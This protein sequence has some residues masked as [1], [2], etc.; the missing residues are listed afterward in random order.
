MSNLWDV[1]INYLISR[2]AYGRP[3][4]LVINEVNGIAEFLAFWTIFL[5][6]HRVNKT[7]P[8]IVDVFCQC[9]STKHSQS[10]GLMASQQTSIAVAKAPAMSSTATIDAT[11]SAVAYLR[12][13][14]SGVAS[15]LSL[16]HSL[17]RLI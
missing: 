1:P 2:C 8:L 5:V 14:S 17:S 12:G 6:D 11:G 15:G 9:F 16:T 13:M 3:P 10:G 7:K 4:L